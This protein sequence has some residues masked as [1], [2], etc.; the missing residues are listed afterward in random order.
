MCR[1]TLQTGTQALNVLNS[2][3][4]TD[5]QFWAL[6]V[7]LQM[8]F[9]ILKMGLI[10]RNVEAPCGAFPKDTTHSNSRTEEARHARSR[11]RLARQK[12]HF[13]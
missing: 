10:D 1:F 2:L 9:Q 3:R 4:E 6:Q 13:N 11:V 5:V 8:V 7:R 12:L